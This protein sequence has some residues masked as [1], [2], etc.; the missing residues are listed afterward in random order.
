MSP[1]FCEGHIRAG[2]FEIMNEANRAVAQELFGLL[3]DLDSQVKRLF[4]EISKSQP[5]LTGGLERPVEIFRRFIQVMQVMSLDLLMEASATLQF[6][7]LDMRDLDS[8]PDE[9]IEAA[10]SLALNIIAG[11]IF[12]RA[13]EADEPSHSSLQSFL[14]WYFQYRRKTMGESE[15]SPEYYGHLLGT[16]IR[17]AKN[18][19]LEISNEVAHV[20]DE[21]LVS[22]G[23]AKSAVLTDLQQAAAETRGIIQEQLAES[24]SNLNEIKEALAAYKEEFSEAS[25]KTSDYMN[26]LKKLQG[27]LGF[28]TLGKAFT[29]FIDEKKSERGWLLCW[30]LL[31]GVLVVGVPAGVATWEL[32]HVNNASVTVTSSQAS[33][34]NGSTEAAGKNG[35]ETVSKEAK[36]GAIAGREVPSGVKVGSEDGGGVLRFLYLLPISAIELILVFYFRVVL[37]QFHSVSAQLLQLRMRLAVCRFLESYGEFREK[38]KALPFDRFDALVFSNLMPNADQVPSTFDGLDG[39]AKIF[40]SVRGKGA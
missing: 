33:G 19:V 25:G 37:G 21:S 10:V 38:N 15:F 32:T 3:K 13:I 6:Y 24:K 27:D 22:I 34:K 17:V 26:V 29:D 31:I 2:A 8:P 39:L 7:R 16:G 36:S 30:L 12:E 4:P 1:F 18:K 35:T 40:E 20:R 5:K 23:E 28:L 9:N 11:C 14:S